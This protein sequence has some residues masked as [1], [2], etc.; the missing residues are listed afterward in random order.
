MDSRPSSP[1]SVYFSP[2]E[3]SDDE[4]SQFK[5]GILT[6]GDASTLHTESPQVRTLVC[7]NAARVFLHEVS[8][9]GAQ[10]CLQ[11]LQ[12][13]TTEHITSIGS[14]YDHTTNA[15]P[16]DLLDLPLFSKSIR[17]ERSLADHL[18]TQESILDLI[19]TLQSRLAAA[20]IFGQNDTLCVA[21]MHKSVEYFV[22]F[23][24]RCRASPD[25][26]GASI[27][28]FTTAEST[29][30][31][32]YNIVNI[33]TTHLIAT[34]RNVYGA[35]VFVPYTEPLISR[36][37]K[38]AG[39]PDTAVYHANVNLLRTTLELAKAHATQRT[40]ARAIADT[41]RQI[42]E[43]KVVVKQAQTSFEERKKVIRKL[44]QELADSQAITAAMMDDSNTNT[45]MQTA[46]PPDTSPSP[47][48]DPQGD[49][50]MRDDFADTAYSGSIPSEG[51]LRSGK[52]RKSERAKPLSPFVYQA[53]G[54][55]ARTP[56]VARPSPRFPPTP[57]DTPSTGSQSHLPRKPENQR[58]HPGERK[59]PRGVEYRRGTQH[60]EHSMQG[61]TARKSAQLDEE[62]EMEKAPHIRLLEEESRKLAEARRLIEDREKALKRE[63]ERL[64]SIRG[65]DHYEADHNYRD[66]HHDHTRDNRH[67]ATV[68]ASTMYESDE[69][70]ASVRLAIELSAQMAEE[71]A[72]LALAQKLAFE[73]APAPTPAARQRAT[74]VSSEV[75][76]Q[77]TRP[78]KRERG[79]DGTTPRG[80]GS[81]SSRNEGM[82]R[83]V[84]H[85]PVRRPP[86]LYPQSTPSYD[87]QIEEDERL[88]I[89]LAAQM[90]DEDLDK[91][92]RAQIRQM[93]MEEE[94][95]I[96]QFELLQRQYKEFDCAVCAESFDEGALAR[97]QGCDHVVCRECMLGQVKAQVEQR[98]WPVFCPGC[99]PDAVSRGVV[100]RRVA[101]LVGADE[102]LFEAWNRIEL[103]GVSITVECPKCRES[104]RVDLDDFK[105]TKVLDC[106]LKCGAHFCKECHQE[107]ERGKTHSCDG[108]AEMDDLAAQQNWKKC[109]GC[110]QMAM[111]DGGCNQISCGTPG[112]NMHFC[113]ACGGKIA[114]TAS[115]QAMQMAK[116]AHYQ[117]CKLF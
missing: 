58:Q 61:G 83:A 6:S 52:S 117:T 42:D 105:E 78:I 3:G 109:P 32:V 18:C 48:L 8:N 88:A 47:D 114:Q 69:E 81:I 36:R 63:M 104:A 25:L 107:V 67:D 57:P 1:E 14:E 60:N 108:Q 94:E 82:F 113:Y 54:V 13:V 77:S 39:H 102:K 41:E 98:H 73:D 21:K 68:A 45:V 110:G 87:T 112:C 17:E 43:E 89:K 66:Q 37:R 74:S 29:A 26:S 9:A 92:S 93:Y 96:R 38:G 55:S 23:N 72:S 12:G 90:E 95:Q 20:V 49:H 33:F 76:T 10:Q 79:A 115:M 99:A 46:S 5:P 86:V 84:G 106:P 30:Q 62:H 103:G 16:D 53:T 56:S 34:S 116:T 2:L 4:S 44:K 64:R 50:V 71:E 70:D 80:A 28:L 11:R 59:T 22:V 15:D 7:F 19:K 91:A 85:S 27:R 75:T 97:A 35:S 111:K 31:H 65:R 100:T 51:S 40:S 101:E 24:P